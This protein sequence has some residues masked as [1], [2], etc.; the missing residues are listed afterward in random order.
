MATGYD[1]N[2]NAGL[3]FSTITLTLPDRNLELSVADANR[4]IGAAFVRAGLVHQ[5][6]L[7]FRVCMLYKARE[8][9]EARTKKV[10]LDVVIAT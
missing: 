2:V 5:L 4:P 7:D 3:R 9:G 8:V 10:T 1:N 6:K